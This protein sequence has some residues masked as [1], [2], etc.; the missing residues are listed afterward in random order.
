MN[1]Y[2]D[3]LVLVGMF[4]V[5]LLV[6]RFRRY[7]YQYAFHDVTW[8]RLLIGKDLLDR[9]EEGTPE[10]VHLRQA[11]QVIDTRRGK[12]VARGTLETAQVPIWRAHGLLWTFRAAEPRLAAFHFDTLAFKVV[13]DAN[14]VAADPRLAVD[15][16]EEALVFQDVQGRLQRIDPRTVD[17]APLSPRPLIPL[18]RERRDPGEGRLLAL[19]DAGGPSGPQ[20]DEHALYLPE[21]GERPL[22]RF[23]QGR[24]V[25][26]NTGWDSPRPLVRNGRV[27]LAHRESLANDA[28]A[29]LSCV[30]VASG[31]TQW[32]HP[33]GAHR[34]KAAFL[35]R[36]ALLVI[37][38]N[39]RGRPFVTALRVADGAV[40]WKTKP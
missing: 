12:I 7:Q 39:K 18:P 32:S 17:P 25:A 23:F 35:D 3:S 10:W 8:G 30:H 20:R 27:F 13:F 11:L 31:E 29:R 33:L 34:A 19:A 38:T 40:L 6:R 24:L 21:G 2:W 37:H 36:D 28:R 22:G 4:A 1:A 5:L 14:V 9:R 26:E 15:P 16:E